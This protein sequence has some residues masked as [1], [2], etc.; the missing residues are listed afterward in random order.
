MSTPSQ[1]IN[2]N[3]PFLGEVPAQLVTD[4][5]DGPLGQRAAVTVNIPNGSVTALLVRDDLV[6]WRDQLT[7]QI[8]RMNGLILSGPG[9][10]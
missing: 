6:K 7:A 2:P 9:G 5:V 4:T 10:G 8:G 1:A 3:N